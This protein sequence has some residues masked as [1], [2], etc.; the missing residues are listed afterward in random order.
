MDL[1]RLL[2]YCPQ[3]D[4]L[5]DMLTGFEMLVLFTRLKG[6][7]VT[8]DYI[9]VLLEIFLLEDYADQLVRTYRSGTLAPFLAKALL[10]NRSS[11]IIAG[12]AFRSMTIGQT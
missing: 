3:R 5:L 11:R 8:P 6:I 12:K 10:V 2:G 9:D 7:Q 1:Q 4:G